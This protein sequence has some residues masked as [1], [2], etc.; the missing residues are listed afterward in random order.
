M[1]VPKKRPCT[2]YAFQCTENGKVYIGCTEDFESRV[3]THI[4]E[5]EKGLKKRWLPGN[6][7]IKT[8]W[9]ND[10]DR[11][12]RDAFKIFVLEENVPPVKAYA[13]ED[14]WLDYYDATNPEYGYNIRHGAVKIQFDVEPGIPKR[15][16]ESK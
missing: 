12:G 5:L 2:V 15:E 9:Q 11:Y 4:R 1:S 3:R 8:E 10:Y 16:V 13:R 6:K 7:T 14:Y